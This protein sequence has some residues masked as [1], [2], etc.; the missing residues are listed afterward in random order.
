M[1]RV[2]WSALSP[3]PVWARLNWLAKVTRCDDGFSWLHRFY[4]VCLQQPEPDGEPADPAPI[5]PQSRASSIHPQA[6]VLPNCCNAAKPANTGLHGAMVC[7]FE[8]DASSGWIALRAARLTASASGGKST[9]RRLSKYAG[10][11]RE[12]APWPALLRFGAR[13]LRPPKPRLQ[14]YVHTHQGPIVLCAQRSPCPTVLVQYV[15]RGCCW[16]TW[17][18]ARS[19]FTANLVST[20]SSA[21]PVSLP[22]CLSVICFQHGR[23]RDSTHVE[24]GALRVGD[25]KAFDH[26]VRH[27]AI[28]QIRLLLRTCRAQNAAGQI[29]LGCDSHSCRAA[30]KPGVRDVKRGCPKSAGAFG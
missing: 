11:S 19:G 12:T 5:L 13:W 6:L 14:Y 27:L 8:R 2:L 15:V 1:Y 17:Q 22:P 20:V 18:T 10:H 23:L 3:L 9:I 7:G 25:S 26:I 4:T 29:A 30:R 16:S 24:A 21:H 28:F